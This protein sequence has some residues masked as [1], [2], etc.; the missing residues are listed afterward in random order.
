[1]NTNSNKDCLDKILVSTG[2]LD[3]KKYNMTESFVLNDDGVVEQYTNGNLI[4]SK[5]F[6]KKKKKKQC[7]TLITDG[8]QLSLNNNL[9]ESEELPSNEE[10][11]YQKDNIQ[12]AID[13]VDEIQDLK[14]TL[15]DKV[16][17][18]MNESLNSEKDSIYSK[19][20]SYNELKDMKLE[21]NLTKDQIDYINGIFGDLDTL[22]T[23]MLDILKL[24]KFKNEELLSISDYINELKEQGGII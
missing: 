3:F 18:L 16:N 4:G 20:L 21:D 12:Q 9:T 23:N 22:K 1:M 6:S 5:P 2:K 24:F 19:N 15:E 14:D 17:D 13:K 8:Y 7:D 11:D 10:L